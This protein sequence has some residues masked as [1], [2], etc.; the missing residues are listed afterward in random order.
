MSRAEGGELGDG[1]LN[2]RGVDFGEQLGELGV[3]EL[4]GE[5]G[6]G[7]A[8]PVDGE[9]TLGVEDLGW[10][11]GSSIMC[12]WKVRIKMAYRCYIG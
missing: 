4:R 9:G 12:A 5:P 1:R 7:S 6:A 3:G 10:W 8:W 11:E 2:A